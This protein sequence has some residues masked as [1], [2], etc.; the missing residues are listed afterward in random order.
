LEQTST[1]ET[2]TNSGMS[3][4][5][6]TLLKLSS[7]HSSM[8]EALVKYVKSSDA[9]EM[10]ELQHLINSLHRIQDYYYYEQKSF[11]AGLVKDSSPVPME[12]SFSATQSTT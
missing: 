4:L 8:E 12:D 11:P 7:L 3:A 5:I 2:K 6:E 10:K 9:L 1:Q